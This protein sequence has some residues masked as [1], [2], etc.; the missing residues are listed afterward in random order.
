MACKGDLDSRGR[1]QV[2]KKIYSQATI[3]GK[4]VDEVFANVLR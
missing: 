3:P 4:G 2:Y 1:L